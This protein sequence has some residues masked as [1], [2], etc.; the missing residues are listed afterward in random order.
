MY[1][2]DFYNNM[3]LDEIQKNITNEG[4]N[5]ISFSNKPGDVYRSHSHPETKLLAFLEGSMDVIVDGKKFSCKKG[6]KLIILGNIVHSA[7]V[8]DQGCRFF[9]SQKLI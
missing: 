3:N 1:Y 4:F 5:P 9:W 2:S 8:G 7:V 6:D